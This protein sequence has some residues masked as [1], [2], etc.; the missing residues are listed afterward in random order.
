MKRRNMKHVLWLAIAARVAFY[1]RSGL[2]RGRQT[3]RYFNVSTLS[4]RRGNKSI[5]HF[6]FFIKLV[7]E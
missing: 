3:Q 1:S 4:S 5:A 7:F 2:E 6:S